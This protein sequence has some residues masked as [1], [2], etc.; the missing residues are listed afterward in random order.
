MLSICKV[1]YV[2][3]LLFA[4]TLHIITVISLQSV[5]G[6]RTERNPLPALTTRG[7]Y[8]PGRLWLQR[9]PKDQVCFL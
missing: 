2:F 8:V 9:K 5:I 7:G 3:Y 1:Q 6:H 4:N